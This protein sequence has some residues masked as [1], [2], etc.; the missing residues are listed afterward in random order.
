MKR[1]LPLIFLIPMANA[2]TPMSCSDLGDFINRRFDSVQKSVND[3][4][5]AETLTELTENRNE[6]LI[7]KV[8]SESGCDNLATLENKINELESEIALLAGFEKMKE[9]IERKKEE[10][11]S[12]NLTK[13]QRAAADFKKGLVTARLLEGILDTDGDVP[14]IRALKNLPI[15]QRNNVSAL[16][17]TINNL[18]KG[19]TSKG[20]DTNLQNICDPNFKIDPE[21]V[22]ELNT[23]IE[24]SKLEDDQIESWKSA[25][26]IQVG[27]KD[28]NFRSMYDEVSGAMTK[29]SNG[30]LGLTRAELNSIASL[31]DFQN[32]DSLPILNSL[33]D[34]V[35]DMSIQ[36]KIDGTK[37]LAEELQNRQTTETTSKISWVLK[38]TKQSLNLSPEEEDICGQVLSDYQ[39]A[40]SCWDIM[41]SKSDKIPDSGANARVLLSGIKSSIDANLQWQEKLNKV[42]ACLDNGLK[43]GKSALARANSGY[44]FSDP[45]CADFATDDLYMK[46]DEAKVLNKLK[47][48]VAAKNERVSRMTEFA[49]KK[50]QDLKC[51]SAD[52]SNVGCEDERATIS[53]QATTLHS[54]IL[55]MAMTINNLSDNPDVSDLCDDPQSDEEKICEFIAPAPARPNVTDRPAPPSSY[56]PY[57]EP[58]NARNPSHEAFVNGLS[59]IGMG[60]LQ[61]LRNPPM[62][63]NPYQSFNPYPYYNPYAA[64]AGLS[65]ADRILFNARFYGGYGNYYPISGTMPYNAFPLVSP[66]MQASYS[67]TGNSSSYFT[68]FGI[69]K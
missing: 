28:Y 33:T 44:K 55:G 39:K 48:K 61:Q 16:R 6:D 20:E 4:C 59:G 19:R 26:A 30:S 14:L 27:D 51:G 58:Q 54:D 24:S 32:K 57:V 50:F 52:T 21:A 5:S 31:P 7:K 43:D 42:P 1:L 41:K 60:V 53:R 38:E 45:E 68:N 56:S 15:G 64:G 8:I 65:P 47:E 69:Y 25:L 37:V 17:T 29:I 10:A 49:L 2:A 11:G 12:Q 62:M 66:Y 63:Y 18:C 40:K 23:L 13:A 67:S 22:V 9:E 34:R 46:I 36:L 3:N 35:K